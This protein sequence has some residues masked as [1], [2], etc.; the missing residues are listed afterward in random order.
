[1]MITFLVILR[2]LGRSV[3]LDCE[4]DEFDYC[5]IVAAGVGKF[6]V[7]QLVIIDFPLPKF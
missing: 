3:G 5:A 2:Y 7:I 4:C 1:M 6:L